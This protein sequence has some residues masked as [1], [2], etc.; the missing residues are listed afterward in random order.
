MTLWS[1]WAALTCRSA[2]EGIQVMVEDVCVI[3]FSM[4]Q[5]AVKRVYFCPII[6]TTA[7]LGDESQ[8]TILYKVLVVCK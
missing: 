4:V 5:N 6:K 8:L 7:R 1:D 3:E 2:F